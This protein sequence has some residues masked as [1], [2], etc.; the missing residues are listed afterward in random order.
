[1]AVESIA[2]RTEG[3]LSGALFKMFLT[4]IAGLRLF[5]SRQAS[6][7]GRYVLEQMLYL[8]VGW[9]PTVI[10][11]GVRAVL[12]RSI[13]RMDGYA[14]IEN[15]VRLRW[16]KMFIYMPVRMALKSGQIRS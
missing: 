14:A 16:M 12:Y 1:M 15:G 3:N 2:S 11:L 8:L 13:L 4:I 6:G 9:I 10:G 5:M 7:L